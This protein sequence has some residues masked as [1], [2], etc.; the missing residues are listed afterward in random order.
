MIDGGK[1]KP[2]VV[3]RNELRVITVNAIGATVGCFDNSSYY[4]CF[5][6]TSSDID[7]NENTLRL[8]M[9]TRTV[10]K[11]TGTFGTVITNNK[12]IFPRDPDVTDDV[13]H[14]FVVFSEWLNS[15][16]AD[17]FICYS[18]T[19]NGAIW[20]KIQYVNL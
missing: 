5:V 17:A 6:A 19:P 9:R 14:G 11:K 15:T 12:Y 8:S 2:F 7:D 10:W 13:I 16:T 1:L 20:K 4:M 18:N 3:T